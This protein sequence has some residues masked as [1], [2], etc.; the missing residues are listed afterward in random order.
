MSKVSVT[1]S[2]RVLSGVVETVHNQHLLHITEYDDS[3]EGFAPGN[4]ASD[5]EEAA[6]QLV[7][8]RALESIL[9]VDPEDAGP[10]RVLS[11]EEVETE[12][13]DV[14]DQVNKLDYRRDA[15]EDRIGEI[16]ESLDAVEPFVALGIDLDLLSGYD[17]LQVAVGEG[18]LNAGD[19][20]A[21]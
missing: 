13:R 11:D 5:A 2:R 17:S 20:L 1:G 10:R 15:I 18:R 6:E 19:D 16:E 4:P 9:G 7:T 3:W 21:R 12:L 8:V 14:R